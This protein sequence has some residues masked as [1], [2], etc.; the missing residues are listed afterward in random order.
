MLKVGYLVGLPEGNC[1]GLSVG[2][3]GRMVGLGE[4]K[5]LGIALGLGLGIV[6]GV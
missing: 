1:V 4:G 3:V 5:L 6:D 2:S